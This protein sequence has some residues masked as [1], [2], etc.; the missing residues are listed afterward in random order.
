MNDKP[1]D[2]L[3]R[4][5]ALRPAIPLRPASSPSFS[6]RRAE[7]LA[8]LLEAECRTNRLGRHIVVRKPFAEPPPVALNERAL[9]RIL[10]CA[11]ETPVDPS[12]WLFLDTE[13]TGLAGGT[14]TYAFM[15]GI[16]WWERDELI[17][18]QYFMRDFEEEPSLL[19]ELAGRLA[20]R[21]I[22]V[23]FNGKS[24]DWPLLQ[25]RYRITRAATLS[26]PAAHLDLLHPARQLWSLRLRSVALS[27]LERH[28]LGRQRRHDIPS[29]TIPIRYFDFVRGGPA[30]PIVEI[31]RHNQMDLCGL[32]A[33]A[34]HVTGL[35][36]APETAQCQAEDLYGIS[37]L[38][39]RRGEEDLAGRIYQRALE[40]GL[41][42]TAERTAQRELALMA[43]R[44]RDFEG[45]NALWEK[46]L[47]ESPE[48][49]RA[50]EQLAIYYEHH[51][52]QPER[53]SALTREALVKLRDSLH[54]GL[55]TPQ[56]YQQWHASF[57]HRLN[58]LQEQL[59]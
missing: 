3:S 58:R 47:G 46:L 17:V 38:L 8:D 40:Y 59:K 31:F 39:Q 44:R 37:R 25:T 27:E 45:S 9:R 4:I 42:Q 13:T 7:R 26:D 51:A 33:L 36:E 14:G 54:A 24:F 35:L 2:K 48:G 23:T 6:T 41:P 10:P 43:K 53:A 12:Q 32:A 29:E 21:S 22:L 55:I 18:E 50:Y 5:S 30:E 49:M 28:I 34:V 20:A 57:Q 1:G 11:G 15:V 56:K 16:A 52:R 19:L